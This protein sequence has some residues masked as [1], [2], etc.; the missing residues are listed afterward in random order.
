MIIWDKNFIKPTVAKEESVEAPFSVEEDFETVIVETED[1]PLSGW[2]S[3][4]FAAS[5]HG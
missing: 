2:M 4:G 1:A 5:N 3:K